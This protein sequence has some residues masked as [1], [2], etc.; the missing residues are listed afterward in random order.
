[1]SFNRVVECSVAGVVI[2]DLKIDFVVNKSTSK[3][4]NTCKV[5]IY[6]LRDETTKKIIDADTNLILKAGYEDEGGAKNIFFGAVSAT[7]DTREGVDRIL[8]IEALDGIKEIKSKTFSKGY[9]AGTKIKQ[10]VNDLTTVIGLPVRNINTLPDLA[11][12]NA[13]SY[14]GYA[15]N[16]LAIILGYAKR[17]YSIQNNELVILAENETFIQTGLMLSEDTGLLG[18][19]TEIRD[20]SKDEIDTTPQ[21]WGF[22]C[23]LYPDLIPGGLVSLQSKK[24]QGSFKI[25][26]VIFTGSNFDGDFNAQCEVKVL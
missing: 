12:A 17:F 13:F 8:K 20:S 24:V 7:F 1:M 9:T 26:S 19:P 23:L 6:N 2:K 5:S 14:A 4:A 25:E 3:S 18:A 16:G 22:K 10:I 15:L 11:Y 21:K